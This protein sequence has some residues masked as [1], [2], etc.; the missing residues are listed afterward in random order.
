MRTIV[1]VVLIL[2]LAAAAQMRVA[3]GTFLRSA[4]NTADL[5]PSPKLTGVLSEDLFAVQPTPAV[6]ESLATVETKSALLSG[7]LSLAVPGAGQ[8]YNHDYWAAAAFIA[9]EA[10]AWAVNIIWTRKGNNQEIAY[11]QYADGTANYKLPNGQPDPYGNAHYSVV[12]YAKWIQDNWQQLLQ[13]NG[14]DPTNNTDPV[15]R[16][17]QEYQATLIDNNGG[18]A[19]WDKV[20]WNSL[21]IVE[22]SLGGYFTHF[23]FPHQN[24]EYYE[25]IGKYPQYRQGWIDSPFA[26]GDTHFIDFMDYATPISGY[27][28]GQRGKANSL[29]GVAS[30]ALSIVLVNHFASAVEAALAA[31][32]HNKNIH[33]N[34]SLAPLP[35]QMGYQAQ[36]NLAFNF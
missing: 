27:Y 7:V 15:V 22:E 23:L 36:V 30:T 6:Q 17:V 13:R 3:D 20:N 33:A 19:P 9:A 5:R 35:L 29:F 25:L 32:I 1:F 21:N 14:H 28:M 8:I 4:D 11:E 10:A 24:F 12:R 2:P 26:Q 16:I 31:H 18:P 34:V